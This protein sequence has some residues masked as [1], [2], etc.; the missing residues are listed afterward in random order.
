M[1]VQLVVNIQEGW[2]LGQVVPDVRELE[3]YVKNDKNSKH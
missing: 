1:I 2:R 3:K